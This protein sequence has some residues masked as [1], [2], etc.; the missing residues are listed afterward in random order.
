MLIQPLNVARWI[1]KQECLSAAQLPE[2]WQTEVWDLVRSAQWTR[3]GW[4]KGQVLQMQIWYAAYSLHSSRLR[5]AS[6]Q[7]PAKSQPNGQA[8]WQCD[9]VCQRRARD[10]SRDN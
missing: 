8:L 9:R 2:I 6:V 10:V 3:R 4:Q 1:H 5:L 7:G